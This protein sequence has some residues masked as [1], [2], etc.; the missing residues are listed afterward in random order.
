M[1]RH[2]LQVVHLPHDKVAAISWLQQ[3]VL[4]AALNQSKNVQM[5]QDAMERF[6][7]CEAEVQEVERIRCERHRS[8]CLCFV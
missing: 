7:E 2:T 1:P 8:G 4:H 6:V 5:V 3:P